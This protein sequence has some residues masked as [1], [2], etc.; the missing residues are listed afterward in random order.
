MASNWSENRLTWLITGA[1]SGFGL[2]LTRLALA[3]NHLVIAT[4]RNP[5]ANPSLLTELT[6]RG[7]RFLPLEIDDANAA[8][9][10][11]DGL[12]KE[13]VEIDVLV[14]CAGFSVHGPVESF[15]EAEVRAQ[16]ETV[17]F[18]PYRLIRATVPGMRERRRGIVVS[19]GSGAGVDGRPSMGIYGAAKAA[20]DGKICA[21][22]GF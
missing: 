8:Q 18:G 19:L 17:F 10:L 4:S 12:T 22:K 21:S 11:V 16:M 3:K 9:E 1:S 2:H 20:M 13:G 15:T 7:G 6:S 5:S 14:N